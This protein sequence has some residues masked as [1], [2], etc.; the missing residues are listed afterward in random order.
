M[1]GDLLLQAE[2]E[3]KN[4]IFLINHGHKKELFDL[5]DKIFTLVEPVTEYFIEDK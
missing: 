5:N 2:A 4:N 3:M 1:E